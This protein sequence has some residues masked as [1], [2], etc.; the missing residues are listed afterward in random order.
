MKKRLNIKSGV[1]EI[2]LQ[3]LYNYD[4]KYM[5]KDIHS[6]SFTIEGGVITYIT[7]TGSG[8]YTI[9]DSDITFEG[10]EASFHDGTPFWNNHL[11]ELLSEGVWDEVLDNH[12]LSAENSALCDMILDYVAK[13][14]LIDI[15]PV[16]ND[17]EKKTE[18]LAEQYSCSARSAIFEIDMS[19]F[20]GQGYL[21]I[22]NNKITIAEGAVLF[23]QLGTG[24]LFF[25]TVKGGNEF[26]RMMPKPV[27]QKVE[28]AIKSI[29]NKLGL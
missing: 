2:I 11:L 7:H 25:R 16:I 17:W 23:L 12:T 4:Y 27:A 10:L 24:D 29:L 19:E 14:E 22:V 15:S 8:K 3:S 1:K 13:N 9:T 18:Y 6:P 5:K 26:P 21:N 20:S 28:D